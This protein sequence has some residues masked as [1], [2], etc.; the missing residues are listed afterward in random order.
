MHAG[1]NWSIYPAIEVTVLVSSTSPLHHLQV[2]VFWD[3]FSAYQSPV[4]Y[5]RLVNLRK[6]IFQLS[7]Y[8]GACDGRISKDFP[9]A[10]H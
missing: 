1:H 5:L 9:V 10:L 4:C 7:N 6:P 8:I 2:G 3:T